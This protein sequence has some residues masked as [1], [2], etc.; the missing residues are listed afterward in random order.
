MKII[1]TKLDGVLLIE[2]DVFED[3]R[4]F[5]MESY[6][7]RKCQELGLDYDFV[8]DN[9]SLSV[10]AGT[11]RGLH[12]QLYPKAQTKMVRVVKGAIYDVVVDI[13]RHSSTFGQWIAVTLSA[14]NKQQLLVPEGFAHGFCTMEANTEVLYKVDEFYSPEHDRGILWN[15]HALGISWP[16][17][18]PI[19]S[20]KDKKQPKLKDAE[21][22]F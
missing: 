22:N 15:D 3:S 2:P 13:R 8:Q 9:H 18:N 12:Y 14:E 19:L 21:I 5:F 1:E 6:H 10:E 11:I 7:K 4:G 20:E 17:T 16:T